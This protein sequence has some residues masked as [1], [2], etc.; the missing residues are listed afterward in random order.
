MQKGVL[1]NKLQKEH[2]GDDFT[3]KIWSFLLG[4]RA[5]RFCIE[6]ITY[7]QY[8]QPGMVAYKLMPSEYHCH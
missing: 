8:T 5:L 6:K 4:N 7:R 2:S 1:P 3:S